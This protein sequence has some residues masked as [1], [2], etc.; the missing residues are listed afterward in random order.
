MTSGRQGF[1]F[2]DSH[3][4]LF[5]AGEGSPL[6]KSTQQESYYS[7]TN[8][9][10]FE[11]PKGI[12]ATTHTVS[13]SNPSATIDLTTNTISGVSGDVSIEFTGI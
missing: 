6:Q 8:T 11:Y 2:E 10:H 13:V 12:N 9:I 3:G 1:I 5:A 7:N 4:N